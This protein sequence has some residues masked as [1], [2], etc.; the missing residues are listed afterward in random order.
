LQ[1]RFERLDRAFA[2]GDFETLEREA[3]TL[4]GGAGNISAKARSALAF[5]LE[6]SSSERNR[7][8]VH[9]IMRAIAKK[10]PATLAAL[11]YR[12]DAAA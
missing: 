7:D 10:A 12:R 11:H 1:D 8:K 4:I 3:H 2:S 5:E 9:E 6:T